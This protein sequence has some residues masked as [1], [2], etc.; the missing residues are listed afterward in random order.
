MTA[1]R[2][3]PVAPSTTQRIFTTKDYIK[4][5]AEKTVVSTYRDQDL[6]SLVEWIDPGKSFEEPHWHPQSAHVFV[7]VEGEGEALVGSGKWETI[8]A[9]QFIVNPREKV[10]AMRNTSKT[11]RLAWVCVHIPGPGHS[12]NIVSEDHE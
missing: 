12:T 9:G 1:P 7:V 4:E 3:S 2:P 10:H 11:D 6:V 5:N 8:K